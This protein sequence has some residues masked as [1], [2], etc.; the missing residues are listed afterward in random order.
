MQGMNSAKVRVLVLAGLLATASST[1]GE[2]TYTNLYTLGSTGG[3]TYIQGAHGD[4]SPLKLQ[5]AGFANLGETSHATLWTDSAPAGINLHPSAGFD[6]SQANSTDG[7]QQVGWGHLPATTN[8]HALLWTGSAESVVDLHPNAGYS[9]SVAFGVGGSQQVGWGNG[10]GTFHPSN[11]LLWSG[12]AASVVNLNPAGFTTTAARATNGEQQVGSGAGAAT[13]GYTHALLWH[14]TAASA[15]DIHPSAF[16]ESS[17]WGLSARQQVGF[18]KRSATG[19]YHAVVWEGSSASA[20]DLNPS[21]FDRSFAYG[22]NGTQQVGY[23]YPSTNIEIARALLWSGTADS[24]ID[25]G[26]LLPPT[27]N[28]SY[29]LS[30]S[31]NTVYGYATERDNL[32]LRYHAIA[33]HI[34]EPTS[35]ALIVLGTISV[36]RRRR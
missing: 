28:D 10:T 36:A 35:F 9:S 27:F 34:P 8:Y 6:S 24:Y 3:F 5:F 12:T 4:Q 23:G 29:A 33:W 11:A 30:I 16:W 21:E 15:V 26:T 17:A 20:A 18:G 1:R 14:G 2:I 25:L 32:A 7:M 19:K 22:T 31:G 13:T